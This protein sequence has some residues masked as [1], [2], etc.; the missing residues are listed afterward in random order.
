LAGAAPSPAEGHAFIRI[1]SGSATGQ[2][3][4]LTK[5]VTTVGKPGLAV[6]A[7]TRRS[8]GYR[9]TLLPAAAQA[10]HSNTQPLEAEAVPLQHG[11]V[12]ELAGARIQF[13]R[14]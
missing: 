6:A 13:L 2:L 12:I 3:V 5:A 1:L 9:V 10:L 14:D 7:I 11:D 8:A 4:G